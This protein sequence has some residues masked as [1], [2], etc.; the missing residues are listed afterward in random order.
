[1]LNRLGYEAWSATSG[2]EAVTRFAEAAAE[3][4]AV[5]LDLTMPGMNGLETLRRL[6]A[7]RRDVPVILSSGY[8]EIDAKRRFE[9]EDLAGFIQ[10][11]YTSAQLADKLTRVLKP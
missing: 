11:P 5:L 10:K 4:S 6:K 3:I 1:M 9:G 7:L 8:T 2:A